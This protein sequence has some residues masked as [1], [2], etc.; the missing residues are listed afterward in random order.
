M[1]NFKNILDVMKFFDTEEKCHK[2]LK[3]IFWK[4]GKKC[5][6]CGSNKVME[7]KSDFKKNRCY[8]CKSDFSIRKN[9]IFDD[10]RLP[11]QKWFMA[12]YLI[13]SNKKGISSVNLA[14]QIGTT[15]KTAW[16]LLHR[17][18]E[19]FK[20]NF[21]NESIE[22]DVEIDETYI[23]GKDS[24]KHIGA[25]TQEKTIILGMV[26][27]DTK[28]VKAKK[29]DNVKFETLYKEIV[30]V[31]RCASTII[32][33]ELQSYKKLKALYIHKTVNH[34]KLEYS[35]EDV[36]NWNR[37][38]FKVHTNTI[39]GF[40]SLFKRG[41]YGIYHWTSKKHIDNYVNEYSFKYNTKKMENN[42]RFL[43]Y[44]SNITNTKLTYK[45]LINR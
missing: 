13:N 17:I 29:I 18:R 19:S 38:A 37:E 34:S 30:R 43:Y 10:S 12:I 25:K 15:Q 20:T 3:S 1:K 32:T 22:G 44:I 9:T 21:F 31:V 28:Q 33:D 4:E 26:N 23:G 45:Q 11:L 35:R 39:E 40:W 16:Y 7:Y 27:R 6:C 5:P 41:V 8:D 14:E 36:R 2:Y 24:N 42:Q